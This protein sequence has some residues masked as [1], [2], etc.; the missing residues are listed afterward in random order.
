MKYVGTKVPTYIIPYIWLRKILRFHCIILILTKKSWFFS[1]LLF[2][3]L[4]HNIPAVSLDDCNF[5]SHL[6]EAKRKALPTNGYNIKSETFVFRPPST[7]HSTFLLLSYVRVSLL[8]SYSCCSYTLRWVVWVGRYSCLRF[9]TL[10][11]AGPTTSTV[12]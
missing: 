7:V 5:L 3:A 4:L 2:I 9:T 8:S 11:A 12:N 6:S 1:S 10:T